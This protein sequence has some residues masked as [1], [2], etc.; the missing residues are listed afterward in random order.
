MS[1][2]PDLVRKARSLLP[3][4]LSRLA[5]GDAFEPFEIPLPGASRP[6]TADDLLVRHRDAKHI[7]EQ[8][9]ALRRASVPNRALGMQTI[10]VAM[11]IRTLA[12]LA[13]LVDDRH[14]PRFSHL[15]RATIGRL[16]GIRSHW[17]DHPSDA[18]A[19]RGRWSPIVRALEWFRDN[20]SSGLR[21]REI[22]WSLHGKFVEENESTLRRLLPLVSGVPTTDSVV[23]FE[24]L[25]GLRPREPQWR[26]RLLDPRILPSLPP[27]DL[28]MSLEDWRRLLPHP[29]RVVVVENLES[30]LAL[31]ART[32]TIAI[33]GRGFA[34]VRLAAWLGDA[35]AAWYWGDLDAQG[36]EI[37][38]LLRRE[39]PAVRSVAMDAGVLAMH[40]HLASR[41]TG[42]PRKEL[43]RLDRAEWDAYRKVADGDLRLEQEK[44]P[45][46]WVERE[47]DGVMDHVDENDGF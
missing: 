33:W 23:P 38:D 30:F 40:P 32:G 28:A 26:V 13:R 36:F 34:V 4:I 45:M 15:V 46:R 6:R 21:P 12:D 17:I 16:P 22:P 24:T 27:R 11:E 2:P 25:A 7:E 18:W 47:L 8:G 35:D 43:E 14:L 1:L 41:G 42:A 19:L 37:L 20:P 5:A 29:R 44:L 3:E 9:F 31:G 10:P 39:V